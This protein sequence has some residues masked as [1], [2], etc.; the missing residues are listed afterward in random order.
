M[1]DRDE[2]MGRIAG[3]CLIGFFAI[4]FACLMF[5]PYDPQP[6]EQAR[7]DSLIAIIDS[8][9]NELFVVNAKI[10]LYEALR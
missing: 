10:K 9:E 8:L 3:W 2:K 1:Y 7:Q 5:E 6:E 4:L